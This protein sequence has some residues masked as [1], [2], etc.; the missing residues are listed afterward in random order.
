[1]NKLKDNQ[2][3]KDCLK[4]I[5]KR[6]PEAQASQKNQWVGFELPMV[7]EAQKSR[8]MQEYLEGLSD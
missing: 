7:Y 5:E 3:F 6:F 8:N 4:D 2:A 1:M